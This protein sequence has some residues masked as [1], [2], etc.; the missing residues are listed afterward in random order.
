MYIKFDNMK[1]IEHHGE[2]LSKVLRIKHVNVSELARKLEVSRQ[3]IHN[4]YD[5]VYIPEERWEMI[6]NII[7]VDLVSEVFPTSK[8]SSNESAQ[9]PYLP[10]HITVN[11]DLN[12][13]D[14]I[15]EMAIKKLTKINEVLKSV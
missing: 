14:D 5:A 7:G 2:Y 11:I 15:L 13:D 1:S 9:S 12:G 8:N 3:T 4:W 10:N 6:G